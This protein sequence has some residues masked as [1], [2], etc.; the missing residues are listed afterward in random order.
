MR[1]VS[2]DAKEIIGIFR[3]TNEGG[4][5]ESIDRRNSK[6]IFISDNHKGDAKD[7]ELIKVGL[8]PGKHYGMSRAKVIKP[9]CDASSSGAISMIAIH[10]SDIPFEFSEP[11]LSATEKLEQPKENQQQSTEN[12][13]KP[14]ENLAQTLQRLTAL[15]SNN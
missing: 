2:K 5:L 8:I 15:D 9:I 13:Q 3:E 1:H 10:E 12:L 7:G 14:K 6:D 11:L 4:L